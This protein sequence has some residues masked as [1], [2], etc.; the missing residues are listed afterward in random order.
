[1]HQITRIPDLDPAE[2]FRT[3]QKTKLESYFIKISG[4]VCPHGTKN[5]KRT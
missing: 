2:V 4:T 3:K 1:M 5:D